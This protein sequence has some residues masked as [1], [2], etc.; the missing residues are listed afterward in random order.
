MV[1]SPDP[2]V[3]EIGPTT[4]RLQ[5]RVGARNVYQYLVAS[6]DRGEL[7]LIDTGMSE[8]PREVIIPALRSLGLREDDLAAI[9][10]THPDV[11]HQG[12]LAGLRE[13]CA[14]AVTA[15]G[16]ADQAMVSDPE[17]LLADR[18]ACYDREHG[19]GPSVA[20]LRWIRANYGAR[21]EIDVTYS[22]GETIRVGD[23][24]LEVFAAPGHSAGH[25]ALFERETG[26]LFSSDAV[27]WR[28]CPGAD[29]SPALCPT[30]EEVEDYLAT[31]DMIE[32][33]APSEMHSGHWPMRSGAEVMTFLGESR[34][35]VEKVDAVVRHHLARPATLAELCRSVQAEAGPWDSEPEMLRFAVSGHLRRLLRRGVVETVETTTTPLRFRLRDPDSAVVPASSLERTA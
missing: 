15:C 14:N 13:V 16:F 5:G 8:T 23:R 29:G 28:A 7:L 30:Y 10:V 27:H 11:D 19:I 18:Y 32:S 24:A 21:T 9:V 1:I 34:A 20:E 26:L 33:L 25:L 12:G 31:I 6:D 22:G 35:F 4:W 3:A 17:K 2:I